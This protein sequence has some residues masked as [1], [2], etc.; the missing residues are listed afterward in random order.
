MKTK[1]KI[2]IADDDRSVRD[3]IQAVFAN[4][5]QLQVVEACDGT[6]A[7]KY[8]RENEMDL[9]LADINMPGISGFELLEEIRK[10]SPKLP[11]IMITGDPE[12]ESAVDCMR[13]G[14]VD[15]IAKPFDVEKVE[16]VIRN[17]LSKGIKY[18]EYKAKIIQAPIIDKNQQ[19]LASYKAIRILGEGNMALVYFAEKEIDNQLRQFA[20]KVFKLF[21][22]DEKSW[23]MQWNRFV[24][25]AE[26][27]ISV[28]HK[29]I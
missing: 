11:V 28:D 27:A 19:L 10:I 18:K 16:L 3:L 2:L 8:L 23:N 9:V 29:N 25:E 26:A 12:V 13:L 14:V 6:Q 4:D 1:F 7:I 15:Y 22:F 5:E 20:I 24:N 17:V 21:D